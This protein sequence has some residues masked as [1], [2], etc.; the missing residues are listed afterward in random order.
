MNIKLP[1]RLRGFSYDRVLPVEL[2][3]FDVDVLLPAIFFQVVS[4]GKYRGKK[5][6]DPE[7]VD[8]FVDGLANHRDVEGFDDEQGRRVLGRLVRTA[9][10]QTGR[11][12]QGKRGKQMVG[13]TGYSILTF[14]PGF[15]A[16]S[17]AL[18][19]VPSL[20]YRMMRDQ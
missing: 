17:S 4:G 19:K 10:V 11:K 15:P 20:I 5:A 7:K 12:G 16:E 9:L 6:N 18:R 8:E 2:N 13:L 1:M 3:S 14:K